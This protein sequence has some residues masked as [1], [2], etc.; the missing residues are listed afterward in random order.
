[1]AQYSVEIPRKDRGTVIGLVPGEAVTVAPA[2]LS[3][4][5]PRPDVIVPSEQRD[6]QSH[7]GGYGGSDRQC[8]PRVTTIETVR[9][10]SPRRGLA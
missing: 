5:A 7:R 2:G 1:M 10:A 8:E 6:D 4:G 3:G 9:R